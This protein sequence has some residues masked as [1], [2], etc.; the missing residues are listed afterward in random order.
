MCKLVK[1][2]PLLAS[3]GGKPIGSSSDLPGAYF[4]SFSS[5][6]NDSDE[7]LPE[8]LSSPSRVDNG[9]SM[10]KHFCGSMVFEALSSGFSFEDNRNEPWGLVASPLQR[11]RH[12]TM[13]TQLPVVADGP[14]EGNWCFS[15]PLMKKEDAL[16]I[17]EFTELFVSSAEREEWSNCG[18]APLSGIFHHR[19]EK[20]IDTMSNTLSRSSVAERDDNAVQPVECGR[21][22]VPSEPLRSFSETETSSRRRSL[23]SYFIGKSRSFSSLSDVEHIQSIQDLAKAPLPLSKRRRV[24][25]AFDDKDHHSAA[26]PHPPLH[27]LHHSPLHQMLEEAA[28]S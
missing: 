17:Q 7:S 13:A 2:E 24:I 9:K 22:S 26:P 16:P 21:I 10:E 15:C 3:M 6:S 20:C 8:L 1:M 5:E 14:S 28:D 12:A 4:P 23:S 27:L 25:T 18:E 19:P 11:R